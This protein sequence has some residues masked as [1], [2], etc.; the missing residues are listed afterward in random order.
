MPPAAPLATQ[1]LFKGQPAAHSGTGSLHEQPSKSVA[2]RS[3][4]DTQAPTSGAS[5]TACSAG[6]SKKK[7]ATS[8]T[9]A[10]SSSTIPSRAATTST[11]TVSSKS[12][13]SINAT[14]AAAAA[15]STALAAAK[16]G[17]MDQLSTALSAAP[18]AA[19]LRDMDG[20]CCLH[21]AAGYGHEECVDLLLSKGGQ[22]AV[23]MRDAN[24]DLPLHL[25]AQQ[26]QPMC[27]YNI[28]K[29][30]NPTGLAH[31]VILFCTGHHVVQWS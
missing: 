18:A 8:T 5:K 27:A 19:G 14:A 4:A 20:R 7:K 12:G 6:N 31:L 23:R 21:Y 2:V 29:V 25:A 1:D 17:L 28:A 16:L 3:A 26:G 9:A 15:A 22:E 13:S 10:S 24:G 11:A 30:T